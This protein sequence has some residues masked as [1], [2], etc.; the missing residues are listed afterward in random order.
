MDQ[1]FAA[2]PEHRF[3]ARQWS[4]LYETEPEPIDVSFRTSSAYAQVIGGDFPD[5]EMI[6]EAGVDLVTV[7]LACDSLN[8]A[9][10]AILDFGLHVQDVQPKQLRLELV[11]WLKGV[12]RKSDANE[13]DANFV[14]ERSARDVLGQTLQLISVVYNSEDPVSASQLAARCDLDQ[15][16]SAL[17]HAVALWLCSTSGT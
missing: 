15:E 16:F 5:A 6:A 3:A 7:H 4:P 14:T 11:D 10:R 8:A 2:T 12:N 13:E 17:H 9:R 1:T